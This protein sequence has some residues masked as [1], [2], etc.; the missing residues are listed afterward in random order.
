M[1]TEETRLCARLNEFALPRAIVDYE[2]KR[3][4]AWNG[5]FLTL[6]GYSEEELQNLE[7]GKVLLLGSDSELE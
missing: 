1:D 3:F 7:P 4:V 2:A 5:R 6:T